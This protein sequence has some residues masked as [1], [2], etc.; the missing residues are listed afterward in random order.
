MTGSPESMVCLGYDNP[1][2]AQE[3]LPEL[4]DRRGLLEVEPDDGPAF[5]LTSDHGG[6]L[7]FLRPDQVAV[8]SPSSSG[9]GVTVVCL[10][11]RRS[12]LRHTTRLGNRTG[13][14]LPA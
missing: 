6:A 4:Q 10:T 12:A 13:G 5:T 7:E 11:T 2:R 9:P 1:A 3:L 8:V 14:R